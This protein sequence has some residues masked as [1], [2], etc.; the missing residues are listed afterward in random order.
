[1]KGATGQEAGGWKDLWSNPV[2]GDVLRRGMPWLEDVAKFAWSVGLVS[3]DKAKAREMEE[4][5]I[6]STCLAGDLDR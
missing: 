3:A 2:L 4:E 5:K 6:E 1:M